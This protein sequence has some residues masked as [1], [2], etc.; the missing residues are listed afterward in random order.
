MTTQL[1]RGKLSASREEPASESGRYNGDHDGASFCWH[2]IS[3]LRTQGRAPIFRGIG[4][5]ETDGWERTGTRSYCDWWVGGIT[6]T[7][8]KAGGRAAR[9]PTG[10][11][12]GSHSYF[13]RLS[14]LPAAD[15]PGLW[16]APHDRSEREAKAR[17]GSDLRGAARPA[18]ASGRRVRGSQPGTA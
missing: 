5:L 6:G 11:D 7:A 1:S 12:P 9:G 18:F 8:A 2:E 13:Q 17:A 16:V 10:I 3:K 4:H 15:P 14:E